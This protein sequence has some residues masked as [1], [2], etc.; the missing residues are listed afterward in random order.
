MSFQGKQFPKDVIIMAV[1][2]YL[3]YALSYRNVE[4]LIKDWNTDLDHSTVQRWVAEYGTYLANKVRKYLARNFKRSWRLDETYIKV[5]GKWCY[6]YR[7]VDKDGDSIFCYLSKTRDHKAALTCIRGAI[8]I[9]RF[10]P[11]KINSDG[12]PANELAVKIINQE[13]TAKYQAD[14]PGFCGPLKP[15]IIYTKVK[16]CNNILEQDHRNIKRITDPMLG[17][18]DFDS[19][20]STIS[21]IEAMANLSIISFSTLRQNRRVL[22]IA[23]QFDLIAA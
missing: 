5:K 15:V 10:I 16:Y 18:K 23:E 4:E 11:D 1:R 3:S 8:R 7:I 19:A 13:L 2:W 21:G 17:F 22:S 9:A 6:L 12:N 14:D 20:V